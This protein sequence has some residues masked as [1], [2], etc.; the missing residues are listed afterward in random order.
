MSAGIRSGVNW[1]RL[2]LRCRIRASV[3]TS[4]VFASPG[5]PV[6][7]AV[8]AAKQ[9]DQHLVD[10]FVLADDHLAQLAENLGAARRHALRQIRRFPFRRS[11]HVFAVSSQ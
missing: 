10:D 4:S 6:M 2:K 7:Q 1:M 8:A 11:L 9:R 3:F 5:T